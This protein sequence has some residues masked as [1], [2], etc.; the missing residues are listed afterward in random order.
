LRCNVARSAPEDIVAA[1]LDETLPSDVTLFDLAAG[2]PLL[3]SEQWRRHLKNPECAQLL[4]G[5]KL[6]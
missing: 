2:T 1:I 6:H 5:L 3:W 4:V